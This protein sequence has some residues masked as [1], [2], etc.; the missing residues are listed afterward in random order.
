ML[1]N[2]NGSVVYFQ[3]RPAPIEKTTIGQAARQEPAGSDNASAGASET[4]Q[5][6]RIVEVYDIFAGSFADIEGPPKISVQGVVEIYNVKDLFRQ[7]LITLI[8][9]A[10][11]NDQN[12][13]LLVFYDWLL[14][15]A[16]VLDPLDLF[17]IWVGRQNW[18]SVNEVHLNLIWD[19]EECKCSL[20]FPVN[21]FDGDEFEWGEDFIEVFRSLI[22]NVTMSDA[23]LVLQ[24]ILEWTSSLTANQWK[25][26]NQ[27]LLETFEKV[28]A[29]PTSTSRPNTPPSV[30]FV[31][32]A[33]HLTSVIH[34]VTKFG[35]P[36]IDKTE[37]LEIL[38]LAKYFQKGQIFSTLS[39][40]LAVLKDRSSE[41]QN[42][43]V[44]SRSLQKATVT[45]FTASF[46]IPWMY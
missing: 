2:K 39:R 23:L 26:L 36:L 27:A 34:C 18:F 19:D 16:D 15:K 40:T 33:H 37:V 25:F 30:E 17:R 43:N 35:V 12:N 29:Y 38:K 46:E 28:Y 6:S 10:K 9:L 20:F 31:P 22:R 13:C 41:A 44:V 8:K 3:S 32:L 11:Q 42:M 4:S 1:D 45:A 21:V 14:R 5:L 7:F 24:F